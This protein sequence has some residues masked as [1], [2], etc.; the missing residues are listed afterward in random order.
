[1]TKRQIA[2]NSVSC[3]T[4]R[5]PW[6]FQL[7]LLVCI[8]R[9]AFG[10]VFSE[11][12]YH[13]VEGE[14]SLEFIEVAN[15]TST[16]QDLSGFAFVEGIEFTFPPRTV[17]GAREVIV[18]CSNVDAV[19]ARYGIEN[20]VGDFSGRLNNGRERITLVNHV[21]AL[22]A[23]LRYNASGKWP[24]GANGT[25][26]SLTLIHGL[27]DHSEPEHWTLSASLGGDPGTVDFDSASIP[28]T[29]P[30][31][32]TPRAPLVFNELF[33]GASGDGWIEIFNS[34]SVPIDLGGHTLS[35][36]VD[37]AGY[38]F[39]AG[40]SVPPRGFLVVTE[41]ESSV[42]L[43]TPEVELFL[44]R[45]DGSVVA[46]EAFA[47]AAPPGA[48]IG[49]YSEARYPD[50]QRPGWISLTPTPEAANAVERDL[51][52]VINEIF[53]HPPEDRE[54]EFVELYN[55]GETARDLSG[56]HFDGIEFSFPA[57]TALGPGE[58]LVL[59]NAPELVAGHHG[60]SEVFG[61]YQGRLSNRGE[62]LTLFDGAGNLVDEVRYFDG[63]VWSEWADG[64]GASLELIDPRQDNGVASAW[65][66]SDESTK[67]TWEELTYTA[68]DFAPVLETE[69]HIFLVE[70]GICLID[71]VSIRR[72]GGSDNFVPNPG[73]ETDTTPWKIEGTH[74]HS[75]IVTHDVQ[76]GSAALQ[77]VATGKGDTR[78]NRIEVDTD[79]VMDA[80]SYDVS[81][82]A[83][84]QLGSSLLIT[85][86]EFTPGSYD[87]VSGNG[88]GARLRLTVPTNL[89]TPGRENSAT[90]RLRE[91]TGSVQ[92]GPVFSHVRHH[93][94]SPRA[95][96][97][98]SIA[99]RVSDADGIESVH[100]FFQEDS[101]LGEFTSVSL[102]DSGEAND[103][104]AGDG[105][106]G[107]TI[108]SFANRTRWV[109]YVEAVDSLGAVRRFPVNAPEETHVFMVE[110]AITAPVDVARL[111]LDEDQNRQLRARPVHS[112][113]LVSGTLVLND[114][115]V[116]YD[117][118]VRYRGSPWTRD[119]SIGKNF[120]VSFNRDKP[121]LRGRR[122]I[123]ISNR[124]ENKNE[125]AAHYLL[126]RAGT[127]EAPTP[128]AEYLY[129]ATA[130]NGTVQGTRAFVQP[131]DTDYVAKWYGDESTDAAVVL[132]G[133]GRQ[134]FGDSCTML[135]NGFG[136]ATLTY[137]GG[138]SE[139]YRAY[140]FHSIHQT[141]DDW[142][143]FA[144]MTK[145]A[146]A[147]ETDDATFDAT[148]DAS[149][150]I[151]QFLRA[152]A[153]RLLVAD[154]DAL[155]IG[156]K[157]GYIA[158]NPVDER[159]VH[160]PFDIDGALREHRTLFPG[161]NPFLRRILSRPKFVRVYL[162]VLE[163]A[164]RTY[165][166]EEDAAPFLTALDRREGLIFTAFINRAHE[167]GRE[168][169]AP[170]LTDRFGFVGAPELSTNDREIVLEGDAPV[171]IERFVLTEPDGSELPFEPNWVT[172]TRWQ[173]P[174]TLTEDVSEFT[175]AG[176]TQ[177]E[178]SPPAVST[179]RVSVVDGVIFTR[180]DADRDE[181]LNVSDGIAILLRLFRGAALPCED[182]ADVDDSGT[183]DLSDALGVLNYLFRSGP[184]P[185]A[186]F[187]NGG[188]DTTQD[189]LGCDR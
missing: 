145:V 24:L 180:G 162:R 83:K 88:L 84:W 161:G 85:H 20:A 28:E 96:E 173:R 159:W 182:S 41:S 157:N 15:E 71:D 154:W 137:R 141:R 144:T 91:E 120:R 81:L 150:H 53:Y 134:Y 8:T 55:R 45:D 90:L 2:A 19:R 94:A 117:V 124:G 43:S 166:N 64:R 121:F 80:G 68:P 79:P 17:L 136:S 49:S 110:R 86:G 35:D 11:I 155:F 39:E 109:Y 3:S 70:K 30:G 16:P 149:F 32:F 61:P 132:K 138:Q 119:V 47:R 29:R 131:M 185:A 165:W 103:G 25:G 179:L 114:S 9:P 153:F 183:L 168:E 37:Q 135:A 111:I 14:D 58:Y 21:G 188:V 143:R 163:D 184:P 172:P 82:W 106:Y 187:P 62:N 108:G 151:E 181:R 189:A 5:L 178:N 170:L 57:G 26:H 6:L 36:D 95:D 174:I 59:S 18:V 87:A 46:A 158:Y 147:A 22:V 139:N 176:F 27:L 56:Y 74:V 113:D 69:F 66:H 76:S 100:V 140:W 72:S 177:D 63:G 127:S 130:V 115:Q 164:F 98:V 104:S 152:I 65:T 169:I 51:D 42:A 123:N 77:L 93:P 89:G 34:T 102:V 160:I 60:L 122:S 44:R 73:F 146:D 23:T 101:P 125:G 156:G 171:E 75:G 148:I 175:I 99:A 167:M 128:A 67:A 1:M 118:G 92:L 33:R 142:T 107:G 78:C 31:G 12:H 10:V 112:N 126:T 48:E 50:G 13:P 105:I 52:L 54:G 186:P 40:T 129:V 97:P 116:F 7:L 38:R 133:T 4:R